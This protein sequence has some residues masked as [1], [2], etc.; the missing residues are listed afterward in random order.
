MR[1]IIIGIVTALAVLA[2]VTTGA[3]PAQAA[4]TYTTSGDCATNDSNHK[5]RYYIKYTLYSSTSVDIEEVRQVFLRRTTVLLPFQEANWSD[6]MTTK[7][8]NAGATYATVQ[9]NPGSTNI[10]YPGV[11][12]LDPSNL[13]VKMSFS[14]GSGAVSGACNKLIAA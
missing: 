9:G 3:A 1:K 7:V 10:W 4:T 14:G 5:M 8:T 13:T 11:P 2:G 6:S 12:S